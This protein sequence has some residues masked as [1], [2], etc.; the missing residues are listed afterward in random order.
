[1]EEWSF[2]RCGRECNVPDVG[3]ILSFSSFFLRLGS[4]LL[5]HRL[6]AREKPR[7]IKNR[8]SGPERMQ[9]PVRRQRK[10]M[11]FDRARKG[12]CAGWDIE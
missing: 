5:T 7:N 8:N 3:F 6:P 11:Q 10:A 2:L 9:S 12:R 1:M 4:S